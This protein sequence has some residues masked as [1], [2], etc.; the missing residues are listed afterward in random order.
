MT[1]R[2]PGETAD[3]VQ[4]RLHGLFDRGSLVRGHGDRVQQLQ[5]RRVSP[6]HLKGERKLAELGFPTRHILLI[7]WQERQIKRAKCSS[8]PEAGIEPATPRLRI[9]CSANLSYSGGEP[10]VTMLSR[11]LPKSGAANG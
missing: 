10:I 6:R 3:V 11:V 2:P 1:D 7:G 8:E 4:A 9:V 5:E